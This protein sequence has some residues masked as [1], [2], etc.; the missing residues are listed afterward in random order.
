MAGA[1]TR[2]AA[3]GRLALS[4]RRSTTVPVAQIVFLPTG[5]GSGKTRRM[6][7]DDLVAEAYLGRVS[8]PLP[9]STPLRN[10]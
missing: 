5:C 10:H 6:R 9:A 3:E 1:G 2:R 7:F 4:L 8:P